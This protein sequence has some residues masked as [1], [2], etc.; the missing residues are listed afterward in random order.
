MPL[1]IWLSSPSINLD[2]DNSFIVSS[3]S[4]KLG[5]NAEQPILKGDDF[6]KLIEDLLNEIRD[7]VNKIAIAGQQPS[8]PFPTLID[9][10]T[11]L[12]LKVDTLLNNINSTKSTKTF[13]E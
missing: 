10:G 9:A 13:T 8:G 3:D 2:A 1:I 11:S 6:I 5:E 4:I 12:S 7:L